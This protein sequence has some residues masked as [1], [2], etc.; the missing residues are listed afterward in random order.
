MK[1]PSFADLSWS[2]DGQPFSTQFGDVYFSRESG[3]EE[4][5]HVFLQHN[6]LPQ[7]WA[8]LTP[9]SR[10]CIGETGF[11][12]GL[13]F[14]CAWQLWD[15]LA[16]ADARLH[17]VS[18]EKYPLS[19]DD[20]RRALALW[21]ELQPWAE[22]LLAHYSDLAPGWQQFSLADGRVTLTLLVGDLLE[23][24]PQL[25]A[26]VDAWFL[27][28]FAPS[29]NPDMWQPALYQQMA[30]LSHQHTTVATFTSVGDVRRGLQEVGFAMHKVKGYGRKREMLAGALQ[31]SPEQGWSAPWYQR[32]APLTSQPRTALVIGAGLAGCS[33]A[34]ALAR[35]GWQVTVIERHAKPAAEASGNPQG[36]LYTKL[37]PHQTPLSRFVQ[38]S[39]AYSLR[40]LN[41]VLE[42]G[43][44]SW[45]A[46]G[47][48]QLSTDDKEAL[49]HRQLGEQGYPPSFL[50]SVD[51]EQAS[52]IAGFG[53]QR[54][55]LFFPGA[56]W[57]S[58]PMFCQALLQHANIRL[59][60]GRS[61]AGL[62]REGEQWQALDT[63]GQCLASAS[64]TVICSA[65]DSRH[66]QQSSHL[67]LKSIR[68]Q[69]TH[70][71]ATEAS[72]GLKTVLCAE[73]YISPARRGEHHLGASFRFDRL[74]TKPSTE[75]NL[76]NL[77]ILTSLSPAL[78]TVLQPEHHDPAELTARAA[79]RCTSP[80]YLP[81]IGPL[82]DADAF[83]AD[84]A[85]LAKDA[86]RQPQTL[87]RWYPGLYLNTAHG[88]RGLVTC[89]LSGEL[90]AA[91]VDG[92]PLPL[93]RDLAEAVHPSRF[94]L[95]QL[96]RGQA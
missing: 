8:A 26:S 52:A 18:T 28:G 21:P 95:R 81:L 74:D 17:F 71:P 33:T 62:E 85:G 5:R 53:V 29:K 39:Y 60:T 6:N 72:L 11:G 51:A 75:E 84:Y 91:W 37:S 27:D 87:A 41:E 46:C 77:E 82:T 90:V 57:A 58:P 44:D 83:R 48:L 67:P 94:L 45:S 12:T 88:S 92:E 10:F 7:R 23:T 66:F 56:G 40:L 65:A 14:L 43:E 55:G 76:S 22:Q 96:I 15:L 49:R 80:D 69:I 16:P 36:I 63:E 61:V 35:R 20:L 1:S 59:L 42:P 73:G 50:H 89:P 47:V 86:S 54:A 34:F 31:Q 24:L 4:T 13:N 3:L 64:I 79:L 2:A 78:S 25:D 38:A 30:R 9:G 19:S 93:P 32:P 68:G 70:L